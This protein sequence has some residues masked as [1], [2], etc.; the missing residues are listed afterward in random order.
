VVGVK[1][2][3]PGGSLN[4]PPPPTHTHTTTPPTHRANHAGG[5]ALNDRLV[6]LAKQ[7]YRKQVGAQVGAEDDIS[8]GIMQKIKSI[9]EAFK[10]D[11]SGAGALDKPKTSSSIQHKIMEGQA[12]VTVL[13][14]FVAGTSYQ[15][16]VRACLWLLLLLWETNTA[17]YEDS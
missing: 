10:T 14:G 4:T 6:E 16:T 9:V 13:M 3:G 17:R 5:Q 1:E 2:G 11:K 8:W 15:I 7:K 12:D